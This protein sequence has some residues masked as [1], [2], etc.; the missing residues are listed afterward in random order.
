MLW[1][2]CHLCFGDLMT[3]GTYLSK[4]CKGRVV[5]APE[6]DEGLGPRT[7]AV[8]H[9]YARPYLELV[10]VHYGLGL[11]LIVKKSRLVTPQELWI[12]YQ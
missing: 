10:D 4:P 9:Y 12:W 11:F 3:K 2:Y 5:F 6:D 8:S 7:E 1:L